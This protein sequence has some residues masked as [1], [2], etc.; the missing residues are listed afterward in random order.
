[1]TKKFQRGLALFLAVLTAA[2]CFGI[3][4]SAT[5]AD[6]AESETG[7]KE[8]KISYSSNAI[9]TAKELQEAISYEDYVSR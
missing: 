3:S 8:I 2:G 5:G 9:A 1:M 6:G 7:G 4:V